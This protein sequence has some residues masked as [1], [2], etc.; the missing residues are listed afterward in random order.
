MPDT[1]DMDA[2]NKNIEQRLLPADTNFITREK[3]DNYD[4]D[5]IL[6][7]LTKAT[8]DSY[9]EKIEK[10]LEEDLDFKKLEKYILLRNV[11]NKWIDHIDAMDQLKKGISLR[12]YANVDPVIEYKNEGLE[13]FEDLTYSIQNDTVKLLLKAEIKKNVEVKADDKQNL[14][15]N[16]P[17]GGAKIPVTRGAKI[18]R[19]DPCPCGSGKKYKDCCGK[20]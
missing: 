5:T 16:S 1:W 12:A 17:T 4:Y 11:D 20:N 2:L 9:N 10:Y 3:L 15:T 14:V 19:N 8:I 18:G 13:M 7:K 6:D